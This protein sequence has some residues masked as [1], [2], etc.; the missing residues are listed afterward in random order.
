MRKFI[1]N[2]ILKSFNHPEGLMRIS[3]RL[4]LGFSLVVFA[5]SCNKDFYPIGEVLLQDQTLVSKSEKFEVFTFQERLEKVQANNIPLVQLGRI[6]HP[7]FGIAEASFISQLTLPGTA[8]FGDYTQELEDQEDPDQRSIIPENETVTAVYLEI[9]FFTNQNDKDND[10][11]IDSLDADPDDPQSNSDGDELTDII[12][13]QAGLNPLSSDSDGDGILDHND[14]DNETYEQENAVY[15]VDSLYGNRQA[16]FDLKVYESTYFLNALDPAKNFEST[17]IYYSTDDYFEKGFYRE[18][19]FDDRINLNLEELRFNFKED[20]PDTEDIDETTR[21]ETRLS[22]RIRVALDPSF[23]QKQ[24]LDREGSPSLESNAA[25]QEA[26]RGII[27][28][29]DNFSEDLYML[30]DIQNAVVNVEY[31]FDDYNT[32]GTVDEIADDTIDKVQRVFTLGLTGI[33][34]NTLKNGAFNPTIQERINK[35]DQNIP[36]DKLYIQSGKYH[37]KIRLFS[38]ENQDDAEVL[39]RLK[40]E[41]WLI[42][43]AKLE[44]YLDPDQGANSAELAAQRLYLYRYDTGSPLLDYFGDNSISEFGK[45]SSKGIFG[46]LLEYDE[47]N[48][49]YKY[50]FTL[51]DHISNI[52]R[53]DSL[54][55]DLGLVVSA[56]IDDNSIVEGFKSIEETPLKYPRA[57]ILNPLGSILVGSHPSENTNDKKVVLEITYAEY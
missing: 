52:I 5:G 44:F 46:G 38:N 20:D 36:T 23:F 50:T 43:T 1:S 31:E 29:T 48:Q 17:K 8:T 2:F 28:R 21:V 18:T 45:N 22:P 24:L 33:R 34:I 41:N 49:P 11:V 35:S 37:G 51:T 12:E 9:P 54:N 56:N 32:N 26:M 47:S 27:V 6:E 39:N 7:V 4:F 55:F 30:L 42:S 19:L 40:D 57:A 15:E 16:S 3:I 25:F 14:D 13:T 53:N 10:G